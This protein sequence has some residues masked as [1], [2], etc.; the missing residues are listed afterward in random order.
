[1]TILA[2]LIFVAAIGL[3]LL[4]TKRKKEMEGSMTRMPAS[5][6]QPPQQPM[7]PQTPQRNFAGQPPS[8]SPTPPSSFRKE[9]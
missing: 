6:M 9:M 4:T 3:F 1:M 5:P 2:L 7:R 8:S